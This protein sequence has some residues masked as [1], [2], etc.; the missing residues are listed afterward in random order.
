MNKVRYV[1]FAGYLLDDLFAGAGSHPQFELL[2]DAP[3]GYEFRY[4]PGEKNKVLEDEILSRIDDLSIDN[5]VD[6]IRG[7]PLWHESLVELRDR[8][9]E[10]G[11]SLE[12]FKDFL[13]HRNISCQTQIESPERLLYIPTVPYSIN[14]CP[15]VLEIEDSTTLFFPYL[16][17]GATG[18]GVSFQQHKMFPIIKGLLGSSLCRGIITHVANT[19][20]S[21]RLMFNSEV[22][23]HKTRYIPLGQESF[24]EEHDL[25]KTGNRTS[26][27]FINSWNQ[28][29]N[30]FKLRGGYEVL[31]GARLA[32]QQN[33][34]IE[35]HIR[36]SIPDLHG[37][38]AHYVNDENAVHQYGFL[39][40]TEINE[41]YRNTDILAL[42]SVRLHVSSF[43]R[44]QAHGHAIIGSDGWG[45][46]EYIYPEAKC[47][48]GYKGVAS[49]FD[50]TSG[51]IREEYASVIAKTEPDSTMSAQI[52]QFL[53]ELAENDAVLL[54]EKRMALNYI[55][56]HHLLAV[57]NQGLKESL[58]KAFDFDML[59]GQE[60][61]VAKER[62]SQESLNSLLAEDTCPAPLDCGHFMNTYRIIQYEDGF[63]GHNA[64]KGPIDFRLIDETMLKQMESDDI[65]IFRK[66]RS[67]LEEVLKKRMVFDKIKILNRPPI[68][69]IED[70]LVTIAFYKD[71]YHYLY[72]RHHYRFNFR[73]FQEDHGVQQSEH[74]RVLWFASKSI[75]DVIEHV[76]VKT[77]IA[78]NGLEVYC[79][80]GEYFGINTISDVLSPVHPVIRG[81][82][83][84]EVQ[85]K[86]KQIPDFNY[87]QET[88]E[89]SFILL[90]WGVRDH[91]FSLDYLNKQSVPRESFEIIWVDL[92]DTIP[93]VVQDN[94]DVCLTLDQKGM[95]HKHKGYNA[96]LLKAKGKRICVCDSDVIFLENFVESIIDEFEEFRKTNVGGDMVLYHYEYRTTKEYEGNADEELRSVDWLPTWENYGA[97]MTVERAAAIRYGGFDESG[98]YRGYYC[99]PYDLGWRMV[100]AGAYEKWCHDSPLWHFAHPNPVQSNPFA[101]LGMLKEAFYL[102]IHG[103]ALRSFELLSEGA[104]MPLK[105]H[106]EIKR[107]RRSKRQWGSSY[108]SVFAKGSDDAA[109]GKRA[110]FRVKLRVATFFSSLIK[111]FAIIFK[112]Q[113]LHSRVSQEIYEKLIPKQARILR[114]VNN[115][116]ISSTMP[117]ETVVP[118]LPKPQ[119][120]WLLSLELSNI[121]GVIYGR[122]IRVNP[123]PKSK[124]K[125]RRGLKPIIIGVLHKIKV[126]LFFPIR[127]RL[128]LIMP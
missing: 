115:T 8:C 3:D 63:Y 4:A 73:H 41:L 99:G 30:N 74:D 80:E 50:E 34:N 82:G 21:L 51:A 103:H 1:D 114:H 110:S 6:S 10:L 123:K 94:V 88:I 70:G 122:K 109:L 16:H 118:K 97:C 98:Q 35:L 124:S 7:F 93:A 85:K 78:Q 45:I 127:R 33:P 47:V 108:M 19:K 92:R 105:E 37:Q 91:Y 68:Y 20:D 49:W 126:N 65:L 29:I 40:K 104:S 60:K 76:P 77:V 89:V 28:S 79:H 67:E 59:K 27:L 83:R 43:M 25:R 72:D 57:H 66:S 125:Q 58:D 119:A 15:W 117:I 106:P 84:D 36:S 62:S 23:D 64:S 81:K 113:K 111:F 107:I 87:G 90:D 5:T 14:L 52:C 120:A 48:T 112:S 128:R 53:L 18:K 12:D 95:Y 11:A 46:S 32:H 22:I 69:L 54:D 61:G 86:L 17:N 56:N 26:V 38:L 101:D 2:K 121:P 100:N 96:G 39:N 44:S 24:I 13:C 71:F 42:P 102:D 55:K 75:K 31:E 116:A 9:L